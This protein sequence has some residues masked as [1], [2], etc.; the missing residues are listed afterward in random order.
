MGPPD[1]QDTSATRP[2]SIVPSTASIAKCVA[3]FA[4][5]MVLLSLGT[6]PIARPVLLASEACS[7][8]AW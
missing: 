4:T 5:L 7:D 3:E 6:E 2:L 1:G 8:Q